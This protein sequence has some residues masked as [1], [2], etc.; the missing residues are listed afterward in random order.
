LKQR[1]MFACNLRLSEIEE[2]E[3]GVTGI[4]LIMA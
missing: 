3:R 4:R 2:T 1:E